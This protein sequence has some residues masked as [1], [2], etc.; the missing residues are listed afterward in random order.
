MG[1]SFDFLIVPQS[2]RLLP[3]SEHFSAYGGVERRRLKFLQPHRLD[4]QFFDACQNSSPACSAASILSPKHFRSSI[5]SQSGIRT[6]SRQLKTIS[7]HVEYEFGKVSGEGT[8]KASSLFCSTMSSDYRRFQELIMGQGVQMPFHG[9]VQK[10][11]AKRSGALT[12]TTI[13]EMQNVRLW[14]YPSR[15]TLMFYAN[16]SDTIKEYACEKPTLYEVPC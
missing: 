9:P 12:C 7:E 16:M 4:A 3:H 2:E 1:G 14:K 15:Y 5:E 8:Q 10:I 6:N 11:T 13:C